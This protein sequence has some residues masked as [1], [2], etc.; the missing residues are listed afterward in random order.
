M[1]KTFFI[2]F[3]FA[4][5]SFTINKDE[6]FDSKNFKKEYAKIKESLYVGRYEVS[7]LQYRNF[8]SY[9]IN[10]NQ[11]V[12]YQICLPDT[13]CW[14][15]SSNYNEPFTQYYFRNERYDNYPVV[16]ISYEAANQ[17]CNWL[18]QKYN[19]DPKRKFHKVSFKLLTKEEW[20]FAARDS[21]TSKV[22]TWGSGFMQNNRK[23]FLCNFKH[24]SFVYDSTTKKLIEVPNIDNHSFI[25]V[26]VKSYYPNSFGLYN[27]CGNVAEMTSENSIAKGGSYLEPA[28]NVRIASEKNYT[29]PQA[30]IGFRVAM[31]IIENK[32]NSNINF[33][34]LK[35]YFVKNTVTN[36]EN[37]KIETAEKFIEIFGMATTMGGKGRPTDVNF[38]KQNIIAV[39]IPETEFS[40]SIDIIS[41]QKNAENQIKLKYK[42]TIGQKQSF[43]IRPFIAIAVDKSENGVI[44]LEETK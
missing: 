27:M 25:T 16:G 26:P 1:K 42:L 15:N 18:T 19:Q 20:M 14:R 13:L 28:Y 21:D 38:S 10:S 35:N 40:N 39:I 2:L 33:A 11:K 7:N 31:E 17:Y 44:I 4:L 37:P 34:I 5:T 9:L 3:I 24:T 41:L 22:Y 32:F 8:L 6:P 23:Q 29:K 30:D 36:L 43:T 12:I